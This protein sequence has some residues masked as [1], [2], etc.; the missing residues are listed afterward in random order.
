VAGRKNRTTMNMVRSLLTSRQVPKTFWPAAFNWVVHILNRSPMLAVQNKTP[1][2]AW[3]GIKPFV[4]HFRVF[5]C[6]SYAHIPDNKCTK[7]D[8]KSLKCV[9]LGISE[10][11]KAYC[12]YDPLSQKIL[13]SR[14]VI[15]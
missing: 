1:E 5:G 10:E 12:L 2:E 4:A 9:L 14:D 6:V 8:S 11:F 3:S 15:F 7:L 13:I